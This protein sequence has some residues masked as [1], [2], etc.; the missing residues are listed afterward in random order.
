[1]SF[2]SSLMFIKLFNYGQ[3]IKLKYLWFT[4]RWSD[5]YPLRYNRWK[6]EFCPLSSHTP[7]GKAVLKTHK[8]YKL[9]VYNI[10]TEP[11]GLINETLNRIF[12]LTKYFLHTFCGNLEVWCLPIIIFFLFLIYFFICRVLIFF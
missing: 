9:T 10:L 1:M 3:F 4:E 12:Y 8:Y 11:F 5:L 2:S 6:T 7:G